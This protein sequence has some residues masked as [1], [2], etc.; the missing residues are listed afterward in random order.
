MTTL[1]HHCR[2][3]LRAYPAEYRKDRGEEIIGTLLETTPAG[4]SWP[5]AR[6]IRS[7]AVGSLQARAALS[8]QLTTT[9]NLRIAVVVGSAA[10]LALSAVYE[11]K[12]AVLTLRFHSPA[13]WRVTFLALPTDSVLHRN[14]WYQL[15][16]AALLGLALAVVWASRRRPVAFA[17]LG[18]AA[19]AVA[20]AAWVP[21][22]L[23]EP[24]SLQI[25]QPLSE[26]SCLAILAL[27]AVHGERPRHAWL[28]PIA[29]A[30][31]LPLATNLTPGFWSFPSAVW[32]IAAGVVSVLWMVIDARPAIATAVFVLAYALPE[33]IEGAGPPPAMPLIT[34][35]SAVGLIAVWRLHRQ[36]ARA[37]ARREN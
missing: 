10:Y 4:R 37:A 14:A 20:L 2:L 9:A 36:S 13:M 29:V 15:A 19:G 7:L 11:A 6:D 22:D 28:V 27:L 1:E 18:A 12:I 21:W 17:G 32:V 5:L 31:V 25:A 24:V 16:A 33:A 26:L 3:L 23:G 35:V 30:A 34:I 8:R